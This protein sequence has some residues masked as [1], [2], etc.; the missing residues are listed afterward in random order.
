MASLPETKKADWKANVPTLTH[1]YNALVQDS[2]VLY[3]NIE[4]R[5]LRFAT[6]A[7]LAFC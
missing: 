3:F 7:S 6:E 2:T 5:Y 4:G 1:A